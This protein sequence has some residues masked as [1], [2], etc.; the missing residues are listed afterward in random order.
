MGHSP[1]NGSV[2]SVSKAVLHTKG[3]AV[4]L[5]TAGIAVTVQVIQIDGPAAA[6]TLKET[7]DIELGTIKNQLV[8]IQS[9][10]GANFNEV[11]DRLK[12]LSLND[13]KLSD[14]ASD[15]FDGVKDDLEKLAK[16]SEKL[17]NQFS[18]ADREN[19][20][21]MKD[22]TCSSPKIY[23]LSMFFNNIPMKIV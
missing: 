16:Q 2:P 1:R 12:Q 4:G 6:L 10:N 17:G 19:K 23:I 11:L 20:N 15:Y 9:G 21:C 5:W 7:I 13:Q 22:Y 14:D 3:E 8:E 18:I